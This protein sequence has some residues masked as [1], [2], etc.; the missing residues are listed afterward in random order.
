MTAEAIPVWAQALIEKVTVLNERLPN[1]IDATER[2]IADHESRLRVQEATLAQLAN[3]MD[4]LTKLEG[5]FEGAS[6]T[7]NNLQ[8]NLNLAIGG[9]STIITA[10]QIWSALK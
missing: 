7:I 4:R 9:F 10:L 5:D 6:K 1:H 8:R 3:L 2:A